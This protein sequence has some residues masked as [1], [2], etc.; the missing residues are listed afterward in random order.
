MR[1][2]TSLAGPKVH[3]R[4]LSFM[5]VSGLGFEES[6]I[7]NRTLGTKS[8]RR[9]HVEHTPK[10]CVDAAVVVFLNCRSS[11]QVLALS[12]VRG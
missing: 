11:R 9:S 8:P 12:R 2:L 4:C 1:K 7:P 10:P 5:F 6:C 3:A